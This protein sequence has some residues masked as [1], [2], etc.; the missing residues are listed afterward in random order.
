MER[1][2][3]I[4]DGRLCVVGMRPENEDEKLI[5]V[6]KLLAEYESL[7]KKPAELKV[8]CTAVANQQNNDL[9]KAFALACRLLSDFDCPAT[10]MGTDWTECDGEADQCGDRNQWECW[11]K[12]FQE[13]V[14]SESVCRICGCTQNNACPG[15]C[16][17]V[18][19]DLCS[20]CATE[21]GKL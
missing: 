8:I 13:R 1:L 20:C 15:G 7:E 3:E 4:V 10:M 14:G 5:E 12:Y 11:Q 18:E 21:E 2:T 17:W 6:V 19:E 16:S 9:Q